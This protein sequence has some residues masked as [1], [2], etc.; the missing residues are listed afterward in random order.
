MNAAVVLIG[1]ML[2]ILPFSVF[3]SETAILHYLGTLVSL[4]AAF[5]LTRDLREP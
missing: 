5:V 3:R 1:A 2:L 4:S